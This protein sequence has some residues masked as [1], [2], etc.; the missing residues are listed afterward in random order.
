VAESHAWQTTASI[1]YGTSWLVAFAI[2]IML[3]A[4]VSTVVR[5]HRPDAWKP[6]LVWSVASLAW[7]TVARI[8]GTVVPL[9][10]A[11]NVGGSEDAVLSIWRWQAING[12]VGIAATIVLTILLVRGL[13][14]LAQPPKK[15]VVE[16]APPYR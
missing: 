15:D 12:A 7:G 16:G 2:Q 1:V 11:R 10:A 13:V 4:L 14:A 9:L 6:L 3:V 5:R 8:L